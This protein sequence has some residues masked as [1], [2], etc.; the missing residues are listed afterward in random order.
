MLT[1]FLML[2]ARQMRECIHLYGAQ[3]FILALIAT[4]TGMLTGSMHL[5][6]V[7]LT[8]LFKTLL[9]PYLLKRVIHDTV[10]EKREIEFVINIPCSLLIGALLACLAYWTSS[11]IEFQADRLTALLL[12]VGTAITLIGLY[13]MVSRREAIPQITGL[14]VADNGVLLIAVAIASGLPLIAEFGIFFDVLIVALILGVMVMR[15]HQQMESTAVNE[16]CNLK[17]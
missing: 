3:A 4:L 6:I 9:I 7:A 16:L 1:V 11:T 14:L 5:Y 12:P 2:V 10:L 15:V 13:V 17:E 8:F